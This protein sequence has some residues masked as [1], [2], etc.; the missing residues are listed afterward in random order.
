MKAYIFGNYLDENVSLERGGFEFQKDE[1]LLYGISQSDIEKAAAEISKSAI[2]NEI[3]TRQEKKKIKIQTYVD[4]EAPWHKSILKTLDLSSLNYEPSIEEME[5]ALQREK[6]KQ[7]VAAARKIKELLEDGDI[8][9][10]KSNVNELI[11]QISDTSKNDLAHYI[12]TRRK[13]LELFK[14]NLELDSKGNYKSEA[15]VHDIIFPRRAD[16]DNLLFED[17]HLWIIDERLNFTA[18]VCSDKQLNNGNT[19]R[20]DL[21]A[22]NRRIL[23]RGDNDASNPVTIFEFKR[24][25]RDDFVNPSSRDDPIQQIVRYVNKVRGGQFKTPEGRTIVIYDNTPFYGYVVCDIN[26]KVEEW[27]EREKDYKPM[28]DRLGWFRWHDNINLYMEVI[29]WNKVLN[30]AEMRNRIFFQKLGIN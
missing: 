30:D 14:K 10:L 12:V 7:E 6:H 15:V 25:Q 26:S 3:T 11:N 22:Y 2:G 5:I 18:Y 21:L 17:H 1:D 8:D 24:P 9:E 19:D 20:P 23:F 29:S 28:P 27:L 13:I 4:H 16:S